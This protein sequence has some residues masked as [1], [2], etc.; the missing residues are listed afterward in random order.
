MIPSL[1]YFSPCAKP[2]RL[3]NAATFLRDLI[4]VSPPLCTNGSLTPWE[5]TPVPRALALD[6]LLDATRRS[7]TSF[8]CRCN[9]SP[10]TAATTTTPSTM[11]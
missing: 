2:Q 4:V 6:L 7:P 1:L 3:Y 5:T 10:P 8:Y 9:C 11:R